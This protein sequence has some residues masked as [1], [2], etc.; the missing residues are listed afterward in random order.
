[1]TRDNG[2]PIFPPGHPFAGAEMIYSYTRAEALADGVL[3]DVSET[4]REAGFKI[5]VAIT[6]AVF[7]VLNPDD[8]ARAFG[9]DFAGRLWDLLFVGRAACLAKSDDDMAEWT[10]LIQDGPGRR[11][12]LDVWARITAEGP[13]GE[14][15][16]TI[17]R[18]G[19]D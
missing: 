11:W 2:P 6:A 12:N 16:I 17:M 18:K 13:N 9:Q 15:C 3:I 14:P 5:P 10:I 19:E 7:A 4:A 1:M 8:K